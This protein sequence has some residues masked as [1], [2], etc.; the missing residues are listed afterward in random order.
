[1]VH[2]VGVEPDE[3]GVNESCNGTITGRVL[4]QLADEHEQYL[5]EAW[6]SDEVASEAFMLRNP[7][8]DGGK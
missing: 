7:Y 3:L 1:M 4:L 8:A 2:P 5:G 6:I